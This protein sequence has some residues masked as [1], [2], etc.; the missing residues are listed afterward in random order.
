MEAFAPGEFDM[1]FT[2]ISMPEM[3]GLEATK[4][5]RAM[6]A[7]ARLP[8]LPII[9]MTAHALDGDGV[10]ILAAG[11]DRYMTKPLKK[12]KLIEEIDT[13]KPDDVPLYADQA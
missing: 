10:R 3:D 9:A 2:D 7:E 6:E 1:I 4:R 8:T 12:A 11:V 13:L 5:I